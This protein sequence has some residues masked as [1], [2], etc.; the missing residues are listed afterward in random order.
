MMMGTRMLASMVLL[1]LAGCTPPIEPNDVSAVAAETTVDYDR[2]REVTTVRA[3]RISVDRHDPWLGRVVLY[4]YLLR[5]W[6][7]NEG[8]AAAQLYVITKWNDW[9][10]IDSAVSYGERFDVVDIDSDVS[11]GQYGCTHYEEIGVNLTLA[12]VRRIANQR[13]PFDIQLSGRGGQIEVNVPANY[14]TTFLVHM[15][16][17]GAIVAENDPS[18]AADDTVPVIDAPRNSPSI[19]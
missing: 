19:H 6:V 5:G 9:A 10:Y 17:A 11:C 2:H 15:R 13:R 4:R 1:A 12:D 7:P 8:E 18:E 3:P 14:F 16:K